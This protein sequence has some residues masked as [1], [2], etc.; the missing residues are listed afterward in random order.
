MRPLALLLLLVAGCFSLPEDKARWRPAYLTC[1]GMNVDHYET[2][3]EGQIKY[4]IDG[5]YYY[6]S[7]CSSSP[8]R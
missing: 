2:L 3:G 7:F 8:V 1:L 6:A 5:V 4:W